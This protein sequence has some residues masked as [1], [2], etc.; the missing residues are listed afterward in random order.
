VVVPL[1]ALV[2]LGLWT[3]AVAVGVAPVLAQQATAAP[4]PT[5]FDPRGGGTGPGL[6]GAPFLVALAVIGLGVVAA[7][8]T[9]LYVR[10]SRRG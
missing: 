7:A 8:L 6:V 5:P 4:L 9:A 1:L 2:L 3:T 10:L